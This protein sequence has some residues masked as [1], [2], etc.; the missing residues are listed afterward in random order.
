MF[1]RFDYCTA[2]LKDEWSSDKRWR[3][4]KRP[5]CAEDVVKLRGTV[6][7]EHT[8]ARMGA[9]R[10]WQLMAQEPY[11]NALGAMTGNQAVQMVQAGLKAIYLS[12][13]QVAAD[14][15]SY[16]HPSPGPSR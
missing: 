14:A 3:G 7:P 6:Q 8:L 4:V 9:E 12:G 5:Y 2:K 15:K 1:Q 11:V 16:G 10:L 13:W